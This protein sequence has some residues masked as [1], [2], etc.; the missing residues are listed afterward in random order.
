[1]EPMSENPGAPAPEPHVPGPRRIKR[2][3][4]AALIGLHALSLMAAVF[5]VVRNKGGDRGQGDASK[6]ILNLKP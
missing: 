6:S 5:L 1:M 3:L 2:R 4:I